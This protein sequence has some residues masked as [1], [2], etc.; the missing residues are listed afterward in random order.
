VKIKD[1]AYEQHVKQQD[2]DRPKDFHLS[3]AHNSTADYV[4]RWCEKNGLKHSGKRDLVPLC[5]C[6][7]P[8]Q[9]YGEVGGYSVKCKECNL[10]N[11]ARQRVARKAKK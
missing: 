6:G 8:C 7:A 4:R 9:H 2:L 5:R 10:K 3:G 11:A 1:K